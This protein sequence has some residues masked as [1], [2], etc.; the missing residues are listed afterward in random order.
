LPAAFGAEAT[1]FVSPTIHGYEEV[2]TRSAPAVGQFRATLS[3]DGNTIDY[4]LSYAGFPTAVREAHV[5]FDRARV[6]G[7]VMLFPCSNLGTAPA[8]T[9]A[10]PAN[11]GT[12]TGTWTATNVV[13]LADQGNASGELQEA[14][15]ALRAAAAYVNIHTEQFPAGDIRNQVVPLITAETGGNGANRGTGTGE[16]A[17]DANGQT[18]TGGDANTTQSGATGRNS[19]KSP[20][21][22]GQ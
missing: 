11:A 5:H 12:V 10:C 21:T 22:G 4:Q 9:P 19:Y 8:N 3:N 16:P 20:I 7:G 13:G 2:P 1:L 6:N 17:P 18:G 14:L 15:R